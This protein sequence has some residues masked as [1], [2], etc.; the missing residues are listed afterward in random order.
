MTDA[1]HAARWFVYVGTGERIPWQASMRGTWG[2]DVVCSCGW[3]SRTGGG[4]RRY[5]R[6][7]LDDHR[8]EATRAQS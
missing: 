1:R 5:V 6:E 7:L 3:E 4:L 2:F 8:R